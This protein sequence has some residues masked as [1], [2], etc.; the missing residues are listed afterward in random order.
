[1]QTI[2]LMSDAGQIEANFARIGDRYHVDIPDHGLFFAGVRSIADLHKKERVHAR[3]QGGVSLNIR[4]A[5]Y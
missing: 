2:W 1:M 5:D 4:R 3:G